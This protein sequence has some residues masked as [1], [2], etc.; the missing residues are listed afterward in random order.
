MTLPTFLGIG[1]PKGGTTWLY[2]LL[3]THPDVYIPTITKGIRFFDHYY[4]SGIDWY[5]EFFPSVDDAAHYKAIGEITAQYLYCP[6]C[7]E[8]IV[9]DLD[10]PKLFLMLRNPVDR[11]W[12]HYKHTARLR[13]YQESFESFLED[14]PRAIRLGYYSEDIR[15]YW[16]YI[17]PEQLMILLFDQV[18]ADIKS[19]R[20]RIAE[21]LGIDPN[22]FPEDAG[23]SVV[24][25][26][27]IPRYRSVYALMAKSQWVT[28]NMQLHW[29]G[30]VAK[31]M[32]VKRLI[33]KGG[34]QPRPMSAE[35]RR[36]LLAVYDEEISNLET[37]LQTDLSHWRS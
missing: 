25:K 29:P 19:S 1:V 11:A 12:S 14:Y 18:F 20:T 21:F 13:N 33:S 2:E 27:F 10:E 16:D 4:D 36:K 22:A 37:L 15:R 6:E 3:I 34:S 31:K 35:S 8:R 23:A 28:R 17:D 24:N 9:S 32:G 30:Y 7:P 5:Q 26:G